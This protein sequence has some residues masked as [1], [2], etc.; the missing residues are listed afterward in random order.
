MARKKTYRFNVKV[1]VA[2]D[3]DAASMESAR[4]SAQAFV[5][6]LGPSKEFIRS[7]NEVNG[8]DM[9]SR[10]VDADIDYVSDEDIIFNKE[11]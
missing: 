5:Q 2:L 11:F 7:Y 4:D 3:V 9:E 6:G 10:I 1:W 8:E